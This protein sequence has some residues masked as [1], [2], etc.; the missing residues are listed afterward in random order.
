[1]QRLAGQWILRGQR[2]RQEKDR[3]KETKQRKK[4]LNEEKNTE[5]SHE[6]KVK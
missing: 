5:T 6:H 1:M 2:N 3:K 4:V